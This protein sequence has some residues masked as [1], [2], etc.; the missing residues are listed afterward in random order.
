MRPK[1]RTMAPSDGDGHT[2][3]FGIRATSVHGRKSMKEPS[4]SSNPSHAFPF[5]L[6]NRLTLMDN[7]D[8]ATTH[9]F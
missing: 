5:F 3:P 2:L 4:R 1:K 8:E 6:I 9:E 7:F